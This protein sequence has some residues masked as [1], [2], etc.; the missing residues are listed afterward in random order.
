MVQN[1]IPRDRNGK[2]LKTGQ[3]VK[4]QINKGPPFMGRIMYVGLEKSFVMPYERRGDEIPN[5]NIEIK[6][7][8]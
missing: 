5:K 2:P 8:V 7:D 3:W 6:I 1:Q 4:I